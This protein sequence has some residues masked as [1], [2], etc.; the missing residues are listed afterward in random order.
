MRLTTKREIRNWRTS[1]KPKRLFDVLVTDDNAYLQV[2]G[3]DR[4]VEQIPW[5]DVVTQVE[6]AIQENK[7]AAKELS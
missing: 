3:T 1:S 2:K 7:K 6:L 4:Q 5:E